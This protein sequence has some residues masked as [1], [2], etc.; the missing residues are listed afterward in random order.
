MRTLVIGCG[1]AGAAAAIAAAERGD[2]VTVLERNRKPLKKLGVTGNGRGNLLNASGA[3]GYGERYFG[4]SSFALRVLE[5]MPL[6]SLRAFWEGLGV[7][8]TEEGEG[9]VYPAAYL[10]SVA[11]DAMLYRLG[12][13]NV[14]IVP[15]TRAASLRKASGGFIVEATQSV[16]ADARLK[17]GGKLK[18]GELLNEQRR[19]LEADRVIVAAG[20][21]A[22]PAHGTDGSAYALL[23]GLGHT[24][25]PPRPALCAVLTEP[26][27]IRGLSGQRAR[28]ALSLY[29]KSGA[30]LRR[31]RG[32]ILFAD[33]G[34]SG[35]AA[36]QL[37]RFVGEGCAVRLDLCE[38]VFGDAAKAGAQD[39]AHGRTAQDALSSAAHLL[40]E[41]VRRFEGRA[42][43]ELFTGAVT[44][45]LSSALLRAAGLQNAERSAGSLTRVE[46]AALADAIA[47]FPLPVLGTRGFEQAQVTTG[48][49]STNEFD[50]STLQSKL[51]K[52]LYAAGEMLNVDGDCGGFNLMFAVASGLCAG[53]G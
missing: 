19:V 6:A 23:T 2:R 49:L 34:L 33:D 26:A 24:L 32:E 15:C 45:A 22:A 28:G 21:M 42:L 12:A 7:P 27:P 39:A 30:F 50:P 41:R 8:L 40:E 31:S 16:Y 47:A 20:G 44:P 46:Q 9:R 51:V 11:A 18:Q 10:A 52:G 3:E 14:E 5:T 37:A 36:M 29:A 53:R 35:I 13:L 25:V 4:D 43:R 48:G 38:T 17:P 1:A